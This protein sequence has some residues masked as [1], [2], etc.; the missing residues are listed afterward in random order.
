MGME[1][2]G[3]FVPLVTPFDANGGVATDA[4]VRLAHEVLDDGAA[5]IVV[6][7]TTGE[8][9]SLSTGERSVVVDTVARI[10]GGRGVPLIVGAHNVRAVRALKNRPAVTAALAVVPPYV[11]PGEAGVVEHF[12]EL[13]QAS[14]V[15]L[16]FYHVPYRTSQELSPSTLVRIAELPNV[17]G[18]KLSAGRIDAGIVEFMANR[19]DGFAVLCGDDAILSPL[20]ALG[21]HGGILASAHLATSGFVHLV[22]SWQADDVGAA[23]RLA[24]PLAALSAAVFAEPNP[25]VLKGAL[26]ACGRIPTPAV[27]LPLLPAANESVNF[28]ISRLA[29]VAPDGSAR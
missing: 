23:R 28:A 22:K 19:P 2:T 10:C 27:R 7:G 8:P 5:G 24:A 18:M 13:A 11:R 26:H 20:L 25:T 6:L 21:A 9:E 15:P 3:V 1:L 12:R 29:E 4:L 16:V 14:P 17:V